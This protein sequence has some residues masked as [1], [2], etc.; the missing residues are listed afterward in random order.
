[1]TLRVF[2]V[3]IICLITN[4]GSRSTGCLG[5]VNVEVLK[6]RIIN[7]KTGVPG[8]QGRPRFPEA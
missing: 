2:I 4:C 5:A 6:K 1:M 8:H 3:L 7:A